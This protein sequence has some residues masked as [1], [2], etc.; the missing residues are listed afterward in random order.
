MCKQASFAMGELSV[1]L[2]KETK[3]ANLVLDRE[4]DTAKCVLKPTESIKND[5]S[6]IC[7][8]FIP[9]QDGTVLRRSLCIFQLRAICSSIHANRQ[10]RRT[11]DCMGTNSIFRNFSAQLIYVF[12][13]KIKTKSLRASA[14]IKRV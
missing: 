6:L 13:P 14:D 8:V 9:N 11:T 12:A 2:T 4:T 7:R 3:L 1:T 10:Y 5:Y